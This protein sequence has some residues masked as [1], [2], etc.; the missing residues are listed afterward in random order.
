MRGD[1]RVAPLA[2]WLFWTILVAVL[3]SQTARFSQ[4]IANFRF[5][6]DGWP[7]VVLLC[8]WLG[9]TFQLAISL[10]RVGQEEKSAKKN[11]EKT[12]K[13][14]KARKRGRVSLYE[15]VL[16]KQNWRIAGIFLIPLLYL[17][18]MR[19]MGF[20][21]IT[22]FFV[23]LYLWVLEVRRWDYLIAVSF[24]VYALVLLVFTRLFYVAL[25]IGSWHWCYEVNNYI[26]TLVRFG[27]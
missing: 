25:P 1:H 3:W 2:E 17:W 21:I 14:D 5:G 26:I 19:R 4:P 11:K 13:K 7:K 20:F 6:A 23:M 12:K 8:L 16:S 9:A 18:L 15:L 27:L 10:W 22:P 24:S